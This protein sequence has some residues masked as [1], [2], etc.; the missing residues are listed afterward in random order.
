MNDNSQ[1]I[2]VITRDKTKINDL[3]S[4]VKLNSPL[5][6]RG[7]SYHK[8]YVVRYKKYS[9]EEIQYFNTELIHY[10]E[11]ERIL[12]DLESIECSFDKMQLA[13]YDF[14][15]INILRKLKCWSN[16]F[17]DVQFKCPHCGEDNVGVK[18]KLD[19]IEI[20]DLSDEIESLPLYFTLKEKQVEMNV[21]TVR[22]YLE[23]LELDK[24]DDP[25]TNFAMMI[26]N[27]EL[28]EAVKLINSLEDGSDID[29]ISY[30]DDLL[31]MNRGVVEVN[32]KKCMSPTEVK[33]KDLTAIAVPFRESK[34]SIRG[35][36]SFSK[37]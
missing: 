36:I 5:P 21:L 19:S 2:E 14:V 4:W 27:M 15:F 24:L 11:K 26:K 31:N 22:D 7:V 18:M 30:V 37:K 12:Y 28:D 20:K 33:V 1:N 34:K 9:F 3:N 8:S 10:S 13:Y 35:R 23:L 29:L 6:S 16:S 32:C 17:F 25:Q